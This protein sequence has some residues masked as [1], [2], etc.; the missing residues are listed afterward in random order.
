ML[1]KKSQ[2]YTVWIYGKRHLFFFNACS[3]K[4]VKCWWRCKE[5]AKSKREGKKGL[6]W[7][8]EERNRRKKK[9]KRENCP[10]LFFPRMLLSRL[11]W[12]SDEEGKREGCRKLRVRS[13]ELAWVEPI[14]P[15]SLPAI[16]RT[17]TYGG[18]R[19]KCV[20]NGIRSWDRRK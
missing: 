3:E 15:F 12:A 4:A 7:H 18:R 11:L 16:H 14:T 19:A 1:G 20:E 6:S 8:V 9:R 2:F 10:S 5:K 17:C 13:G